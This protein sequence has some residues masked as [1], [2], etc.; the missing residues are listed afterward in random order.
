FLLLLPLPGLSGFVGAIAWAWVL[1]VALLDATGDSDRRWRGVL[2]GAVAA[3][4]AGAAAGRVLGMFGGD[5]GF[6]GIEPRPRRW[7]D[8]VTLLLLNFGAPGLLGLLAAAVGFW[9]RTRLSDLLLALSG[10]VFVLT[11]YAAQSGLFPAEGRFG[12]GLYVA[13]MIAA[14]A[15]LLVAL[16]ERHL[17]GR[18]DLALCLI[19]L[20][21]IVSGFIPGYVNEFGLRGGF[22][23]AIGLGA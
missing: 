9:R 21:A 6:V 11:W 2:L 23:V 15:G 5:D 8:L 19:G 18:D 13:A 3:I 14:S 12:T 17:G 10:L 16:R 4:C 1:G 7:Q 22:V 20:G